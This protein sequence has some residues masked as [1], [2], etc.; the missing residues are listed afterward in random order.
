M[1][2]AISAIVVLAGCGQVAV[3]LGSAD[4]E[5][6]IIL[7]GSIPS[8]A[9]IAYTDIDERDRVIIAHTI[10]TALT[11]GAVHGDAPAA[12]SWRNSESG[13]SGTVSKIDLAE[14]GRTGCLGFETTANTIAGIKIYNG[15]A[16]HDISN[17][18][19]ITALASGAA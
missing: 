8:A 15:T 19:A 6:P 2:G 7:T 3:P 13:N 18:L 12:F 11:D 1:I 17:R 5:T 4:V 16:C 14:I 9:D 10:E